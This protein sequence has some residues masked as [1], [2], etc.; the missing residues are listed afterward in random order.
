MELTWPKP[1]GGNP[2]DERV[3]CKIG[4]GFA[5]GSKLEYDV[6]ATEHHPG[7]GYAGQGVNQYKE[8]G[9]QRIQSA[10]DFL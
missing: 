2:G 6:G 3:S 7:G 4:G 10:S 9:C 1:G 5:M 8:E